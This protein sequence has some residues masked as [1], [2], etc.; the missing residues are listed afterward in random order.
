M[1]IAFL[2]NY[3]GCVIFL[4]GLRRQSALFSRHNDGCVFVPLFCRM[5]F[6]R[7]ENSHFSFHWVCAAVLCCAVAAVKT[8]LSSVI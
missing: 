2:F 1:F 5:L 7:D 6:K 3:D 8:L 4:Y